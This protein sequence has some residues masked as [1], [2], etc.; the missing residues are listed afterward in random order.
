M[1][2]L[3]ATAAAIAFLEPASGARA[4]DART[5]RQSA[6]PYNIPAQPLAGALTA[7]AQVTAVKIAY[8][9]SLAQGKTSAPVTGTLPR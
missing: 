2:A 4:Q 1:V 5:S 9:A 8:P 3:L 6:T 7:Y